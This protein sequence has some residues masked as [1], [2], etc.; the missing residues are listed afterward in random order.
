MNLGS[1]QIGTQKNFIIKTTSP[2][3]FISV[4]KTM[5]LIVGYLLLLYLVLSLRSTVFW[6]KMC[7]SVSPTKLRSTLP[8][9]TNWKYGITLKLFTKYDRKEDKNLFK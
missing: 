2:N 8:K 6:N 1:K 3:Y 5:T 4:V 9:Y 7:R